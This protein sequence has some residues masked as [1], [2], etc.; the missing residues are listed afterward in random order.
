MPPQNSQN[1][2]GAIQDELKEYREWIQKYRQREIGEVKMQKIR[3]QLGTYAQRQDG[4]QMQRIKFPGGVISSDQ[5]VKLAGVADKY[6]SGFIHFTT[7]EDGQLYYINLDRCPEM[8]LELASVGIT[9]REACGNTVRNITACCRSGVSATELFDVTPYALALFH[10]LVRNKFNQVL[11]RKF[12]IAFE[13]CRE[14]H[15]GMLFHDMG[16][17]AALRKEG[18]RERRG[19]RTY[20]GGGLGGVPARGSLFSEL[21]PEEEL[22]NLAAAALRVF[23]RYGE[24]KNRMAARMKFLIRKMGWEKFKAAVDEE[25]KEVKIPAEVIQ[26]YLK[27]VREKAT[28]APTF[29]VELPPNPKE[30]AETP[31]YKSWY[32]DSVIPNRFPG[33]AGVH[34]RL[35]LGDLLT[36]PARQLAKIAK[37]FSHG[38]LRISIH[39]NLFLPWVPEKSLPA[40]YQA[41]SQIGLAEAGAETGEDTTTCPGSDTCRLGITSA[42]GLGA[43]IS[44]AL[45]NGMAKYKELARDLK[46]K[47]S[48]CPNGCAQHGVANIGF[49]GAAFAKDGKTVP[50]HELFVGGSFELDQTAFGERIGKFPARNCPKVVEQLLELYKNEKSDGETFNAC[51]ARVGK[52]KIKEVLAPLAEVPSFDEAPEFYLD[53]GHENEKFAVR[54]GIK[55]ECAG[56]PVQEKVPQFESAKEHLAQAEAFLAHKEFSNA[57]IEA[58]EAMAYAA[59]VPLYAVLVDPFTSEQVLW[60]FE[61][62]FARSGR[63]S[64]EWLNLSEKVES[65]RRNEATETRVQDFI[66]LARKVLAESERL[67]AE[68]TQP[69]SRKG[70]EQNP[71]DAQG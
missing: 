63:S 55:G 40:V 45:N 58:Y 59:R 11:G 21:L 71:N 30:V 25:R 15:S 32:R 17:K 7:R 10:Y 35:K 28:K 69:L 48:G 19:F 39:Q 26:G 14:D 50:A 51:M 2:P 61:N 56:V 5:L 33:Y 70:L 44:A 64:A 42:K 47:I 9:T 6:A 1:I 46:I 66:A 22:F 27:E 65:A 38:E 68:V 3:L 34:V 43:S 53:W 49:Q 4:V 52:E 36:E 37:T 23:D 20:L 13:G 54:A 12:K 16:F 62:V 8:M 60:E 67:Q 24:R 29:P 31:A 18:N 57:L 41:L